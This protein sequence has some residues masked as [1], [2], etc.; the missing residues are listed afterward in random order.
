MTETIDQIRELRRLELPE[1]RKRYQKV[2]GED[3]PPA[4]G[5]AWLWKQVAWRLQA[6]AAQSPPEPGTHL[7]ATL[8][9]PA[10][11]RPT[12]RTPDLPTAGT[13]IT[14]RWRGRD[15]EL[16][17]LEDG[18]ELEGVVQKTLSAA[19]KAVTGAHWNGRLFWGLVG[20]KRKK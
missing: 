8:K 19:A 6:E 17:V 18:F 4:R 9:T 14:R 11:A 12:R 1:L 13:V 7:K 10:P 20:R 2:F 3:P 5:R 15:L 16:R